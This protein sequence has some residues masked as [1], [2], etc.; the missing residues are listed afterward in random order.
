MISGCVFSGRQVAALTAA[1][2]DTP[3][4]QA[5]LYPWEI[6]EEC[7]LEGLEFWQPGRYGPIC[8]GL[9]SKSDGASSAVVVKSLRGA[10]PVRL[11]DGIIQVFYV[12]YDLTFAEGEKE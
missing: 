4:I 1:C 3:K 8:K 9:L 7:V 2:A 10:A 12:E 6:P 11:K 5:A